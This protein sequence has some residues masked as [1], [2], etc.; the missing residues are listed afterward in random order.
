MN[1]DTQTTRVSLARYA[2]QRHAISIRGM[3]YP[4]RLRI[5]WWN[6]GP[7]VYGMRRAVKAACALL[8]QLYHNHT[9]AGPCVTA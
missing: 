1:I 3:S 7:R 8:Y 9:E 4:L 5:N 6:T 2:L